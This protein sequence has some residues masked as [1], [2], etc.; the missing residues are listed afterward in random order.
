TPASE[1]RLRR[2]GPAIARNLAVAEA[3]GEVLAFTDSDC[4]PEPGWLKAGVAALE[5]DPRLGVVQGRTL[6]EDGVELGHLAATQHITGETLLFE[7][8]NIFYRLC[9]LRASDGFPEEMGFFCED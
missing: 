4:I 8:C 2:A 9:A 1:E 7:C 3:R 5:S 6:P